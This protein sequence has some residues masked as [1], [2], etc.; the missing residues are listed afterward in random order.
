LSLNSQYAR[1]LAEN[2]CQVIIPTIVSREAFGS[3]SKRM[4]RYTNQPHREWIY[5]QAYTFGRHI[6]GYEVQKVLSAVDWFASQNE[7]L[8]L[9]IGVVGWGEGALLGF[10]SAALDSRIEVALV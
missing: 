4:Q 6:I 1:K 9:N 5:R 7:E 2:G 3:G 8:P 10:Y